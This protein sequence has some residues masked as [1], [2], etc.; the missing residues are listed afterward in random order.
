MR[1]RRGGDDDEKRALL[2][3]V[4]CSAD[5]IDDG[6]CTY[7]VEGVT[8]EELFLLRRNTYSHYDQT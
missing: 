7:A 1:A 8:V 5:L 4:R 2:V 3:C 6:A